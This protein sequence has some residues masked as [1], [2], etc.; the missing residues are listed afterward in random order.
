MTE[1][2][3]RDDQQLRELA[4]DVVAGK[5]FGSWNLPERDARL[6]S[7]IF[8]PLALSDREHFEFMKQW[9]IVHFYE[10]LHAAGPRSVNGY[11]SFMSVK[12]LSG[13][14]AAKLMRLCEMAEKIQKAFLAGED[15]MSG[16]S[17]EG[18]SPQEGKI[19]G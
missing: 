12:M 1:R 10:Y 13:N 2:K 6:V 14:E 11:P 4:F 8:L 3:D 16:G 17:T 7:S 15:T 19:D 9:D 5:V 18:A